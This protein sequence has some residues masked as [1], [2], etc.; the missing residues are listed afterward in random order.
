MK[1]IGSYYLIA[2]ALLWSC[3]S[4][5]AQAIDLPL[6]SGEATSVAPSTTL[7]IEKEALPTNS[8]SG[9]ARGQT[10]AQFDKLFG[11]T[12][13]TAADSAAPGPYPGRHSASTW[14]PTHFEIEG[15]AQWRNIS[16]NSSLTTTNYGTTSLDKDLGIG[17]STAGPL[18]RIIWT[19]DHK[20][21]GATSKIWMEYGQINR[22]RTRTISG[23]V[24]L[25]GI[26]YLIDTTL[27]AEFKTKQFEMGYAPRWGNDKFKIGPNL[28]YE[29]LT[30]DLILTD[31]TSGAPPP[32]TRSLNIPNNVLLIGADFE[33]TP[34]PQFKAYGHLG[35][36]PCCGGGWHVFE[37]E[38]GA[39]YYLTRSFSLLGGVRYQYLKRDFTVRAAVV[40]NVIVGPFSG[41][42]KFPG[43]GPFVGASW[44]F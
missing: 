27:K 38:F 21:K 15:F 35:A 6:D 20:I 33:Y 36:V 3:L 13:G 41:F 30:V 28:T 11:M 19:P 8:A 4:I 5:C 37:S 7:P 39:K 24:T 10:A 34:A 2:V 17:N 25:P 16:S 1:A 12:R 29:H 44:R 26:I 32:I 23:T 31:L 9:E 42:L 43:I 18:I 22:S 40:N 14:S